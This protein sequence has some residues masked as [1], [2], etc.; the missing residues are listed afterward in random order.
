MRG[1]KSSGNNQKTII[2]YLNKVG[3]ATAAQIAKETK[4][5]GNIYT[6]LAKMCDDKQIIKSGKQYQGPI[7][8]KIFEEF[9]KIKEQPEVKVNPNEGLI[10]TLTK[11]LGYV[12]DGIDT[13][14][15]TK[16]YLERRIEFLKNAL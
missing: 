15:V 9:D 7:I 3:A 8:N 1:R 11:E 6:I 14:E 4:I 5:R 13:L 2:T 12:I 10:K 16:N